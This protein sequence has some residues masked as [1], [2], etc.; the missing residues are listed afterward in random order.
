MKPILWKQS[1][2]ALKQETL[3]S[4]HFM[5]SWIRKFHGLAAYLSVG[6]D[7]QKVVWMHG[8]GE[9]RSSVSAVMIL[10]SC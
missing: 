4:M 7:L 3:I 10:F 9:R 2:I 5:A 8:G 6:L 1:G